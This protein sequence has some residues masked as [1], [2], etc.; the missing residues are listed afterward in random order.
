M[1]TVTHDPNPTLNGT[2]TPNESGLL[3]RALATA[4]SALP[5]LRWPTLAEALVGAVVV[6]VAGGVYCACTA[7]VPTPEA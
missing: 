3:T 4:R 7:E 6:V 1:H 5:T 2:A